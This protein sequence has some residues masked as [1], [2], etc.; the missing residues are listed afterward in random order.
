MAL[1]EELLETAPDSELSVDEQIANVQD[2]INDLNQTKEELQTRVIDPAKAVVDAFTAAKMQELDDAELNANI[3]FRV[4]EGEDYGVSDL[5][6]W[7][8][9][10]VDSVLFPSPTDDDWTGIYDWTNIQTDDETEVIEANDE[11]VYGYDYITQNPVDF[12]G[13]YGIDFRLSNLNNT[14][15]MLTG[16]KT[17]LQD[18]LEVVPQALAKQ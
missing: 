8:I 7:E 1:L 12:D 10:Q 15:S 6:D 17:K 4:F 14:L 5:V 16:D 18:T 9:Q 13:T 2:Q 11:F 3:L